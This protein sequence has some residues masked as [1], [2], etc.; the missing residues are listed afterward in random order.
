MEKVIHLGDHLSVVRTE[1][2]RR[3]APYE[4]FLLKEGL[5]VLAAYRS[6][7]DDAVRQSLKTLIENMARLSH[8]A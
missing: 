4:D 7:S 8:S 6:I 2:Q 1:D 5:E 3:A